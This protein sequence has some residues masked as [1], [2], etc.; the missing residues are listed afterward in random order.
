MQRPPQKM[1]CITRSFVA[2]R[3]GTI[4]ED[5]REL[6]GNF[7]KNDNNFEFFGYLKVNFEHFWFRNWSY[8]LSKAY[9][10][11]IVFFDYGF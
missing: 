2:E 7:M 4:N 1:Y 10:D 6:Y 3:Y 8:L 5:S 9:R 11:N